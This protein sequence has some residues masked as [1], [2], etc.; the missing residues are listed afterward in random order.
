MDVLPLF[1][2]RELLGQ[3]AKNLRL[4]EEEIP[5]HLGHLRGGP[6]REIPAEIKKRM[7]G[8]VVF[9]LCRISQRV[10]RE[11]FKFFKERKGRPLSRRVLAIRAMSF[12]GFP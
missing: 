11:L 9:F 10:G 5:V 1:P 7:L 2:G 12:S 6:F 3:V 8:S 4:E